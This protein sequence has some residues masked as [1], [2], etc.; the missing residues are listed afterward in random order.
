M[1]NCFLLFIIIKLVY[2]NDKFNNNQTSGGHKVGQKT[3]NLCNVIL[4][5]KNND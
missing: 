3:S 2:T 1:D 4:N 5:V